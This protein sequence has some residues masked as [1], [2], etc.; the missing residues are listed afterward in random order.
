VQEAVAE[1]ARH[2]P[3][4]LRDH[5]TGGSRRR[6]R[7]IDARAQ[8][9]VPALVRRG[10]VQEGGIERQLSIAEE[11]RDVGEEDGDVLGAPLVDGGARPWADEERAVPEPAGELGSQV[12]VGT[13][14]VQGDDPHVLQLLRSRHQRVQQH[15]WGGCAA[16]QEELVAR[17]DP[18]HRLGGARDA[19]Q[20][21]GSASLTAA[22]IAATR[23]RRRGSCDMRRSDHRPVVPSRSHHE[24][25]LS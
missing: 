22:S 17:G 15:G 14:G 8:R 7:G 24:T 4:D 6:E 3:V 1:R 19:H 20:R 13:L 9:A 18:R 21:T 25:A 2:G 11:A 16:M 23:V 12:L 5:R 10:D